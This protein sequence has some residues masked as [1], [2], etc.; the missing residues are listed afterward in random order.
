[1]NSR[2]LPASWAREVNSPPRSSRRLGDEGHE[3]A[4]GRRVVAGDDLAEDLAGDHI[5]RGHQGNGAVPDVFELAPLTVPRPRSW[6]KSPSA[7]AAPTA[8]SRATSPKTT[9]SHC[10]GSATSARPMTGDSRSTR[11]A[12]RHT[13]NRPCPAAA[14]P[15]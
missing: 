5:H 13:R 7:G 3:G 14:R 4:E 10:A 12:P 11:Q 15:G 9:A 6:R 8:T 1:M 2:T